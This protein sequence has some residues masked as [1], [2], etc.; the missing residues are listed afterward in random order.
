MNLR[1][2]TPDDAQAILEIYAPYI[3]KTAI[4]FEYDVPSVEE[5]RQR[6]VNTLK[7]YP[8]IVVEENGEILGYAYAGV[9]RVRAAY[10][11]CAET[12]IYLREDQRGKGI[13]SVLLAELE[14][15]LEAQGILNINASITWLDEE[16]EYLT[17]QSPVF[18]EHHSYT[19]CGHFHKCGYKFG[20]W[21]DMLWMEKLLPRK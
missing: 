5:F 12:S 6:I 15:R 16:D 11:H 14:R 13:G 20:R 2:A 3:E 21:Y 1:T 9:F 10:N 19:L 17:H 8:Y 7:K 18:H 4:T